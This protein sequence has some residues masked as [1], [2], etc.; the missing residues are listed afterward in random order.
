[1]EATNDT[2]PSLQRSME[3]QGISTCAFKM[4]NCLKRISLLWF[5][6]NSAISFCRL[7]NFSTNQRIKNPNYKGKWRTPYIDN[8]GM[9]RH[10]T[11]ILIKKKSFD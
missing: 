1:M 4:K 6:V 3:A 10:E 8:P 2:K 9:V 11:Y 5:L 7:F